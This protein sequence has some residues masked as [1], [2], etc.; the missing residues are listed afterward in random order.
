MRPDV[1]GATLAT[2]TALG[3]ALLLRTRPLLTALGGRPPAR[4]VRT[5][6]RVLGVRQLTEAAV[7]AR[8]P[9]RPWLLGGALVDAI[10]AATAL[11]LAEEHHHRRLALLNA[12][13]ATL[14]A[15]AGVA[16][17]RRA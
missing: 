1:A 10:H 5:F 13:S 17:A 7:L 3:L 8:E 4:S 14:L 2:R 11:A 15:A 12:G 16:A 6:A 9:S